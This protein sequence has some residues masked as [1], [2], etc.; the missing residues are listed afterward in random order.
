M[1]LLLALI[2]DNGHKDRIATIFAY[3]YLISIV[4]TECSHSCTVLQS[5]VAEKCYSNF[6]LPTSNSCYIIY[7]LNNSH[8]I[9]E[10]A[11]YLLV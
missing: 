8:Y 1:S 9:S 4:K 3:L 2:E 5:T 10:H 6:Q 7:I 11:Q